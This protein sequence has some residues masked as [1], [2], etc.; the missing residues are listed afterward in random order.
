MKRRAD[1]KLEVAAPDARIDVEAPVKD[2]TDADAQS[3][4]YDLG[5]YGNNAGD[6]VADPDLGTDSQIWAPGEGAKSANRKADAVAAVRYAEARIN[7]GLPCDDKWKLIAQAQTI[8]HA[9][10]V[11]RTRLLEEIVAANAGRA[12]VKNT[13]VAAAVSRGTA[14]IP[15]GVSSARTA[16]T[17]RIADNDPANDVALWV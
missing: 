15:R 6:N 9:T 8:R 2:V 17:H 4:Q 5:D 16:S 7:A 11:D 13:K 3:S 10:I 12:R 1:E 14:S